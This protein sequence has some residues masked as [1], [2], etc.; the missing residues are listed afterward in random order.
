MEHELIK[1]SAAQFPPLLKE[2]TDPPDTLYARGTLPPATHRL[3]AVVGSRTPTPYGVASTKKLIAGLGGY[4]VSI[5]SGL[6]LGIDGVAHEA[7]LSAHLH[8]IAVPGS[9]LSD[10]AI[11]PST[12]RALAHKIL[13]RGGALLSEYEADFRAQ[14]WSFPKRNRI[15]AGISRGTLIIEAAPKSGTLITARLAMEYNREVM[16]VPG[17]ID[18]A[19]SEGPNL[20]I[21]DG[22]TPIHS[23][24][25]ILDAFAIA[26]QETVS[27]TLVLSTDEQAVV[28]LLSS[29]LPRDELIRQLSLPASAA[30]ALLGSMELRGILGESGGIIRLK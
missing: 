4:P 12:H 2:I 3:L 18:S 17:P 22:A 30:M 7:A 21:R 23:S 10:T 15:M 19:L 26:H 1:L 27:G 25:D 6:A 28:T 20:L 9:G 11:Y 29:P 8:T 13:E 24:M 5:V 16:A 14:P